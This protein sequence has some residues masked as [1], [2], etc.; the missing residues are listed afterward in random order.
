MDHSKISS[1]REDYRNTCL[2]QEIRKISSKQARLTDKATR[3]KRTNKN[4]SE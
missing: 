2:F 3:A 1:E 4:Q